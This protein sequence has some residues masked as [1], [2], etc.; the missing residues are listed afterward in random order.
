[1]IS[2]LG[3]AECVFLCAWRNS[4]QF[5]MINLVR[6]Y[7]KITSSDKIARPYSALKT[8]PY[9]FQNDP[10]K[11]ELWNKLQREIRLVHL[12][13]FSPNFFKM[14]SW[15]C[16]W[17]LFVLAPVTKTHLK[18]ILIHISVVLWPQMLG[19]FITRKNIDRECILVCPLLGHQCN[20][21]HQRIKNL[22]IAADKLRINCSCVKGIEN[23]MI[24]AEKQKSANRFLLRGGISE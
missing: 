5:W 14:I 24:W 19:I 18:C 10:L 9:P 2:S 15:E 22:A 6:H 13:T 11:K 4:E 8:S 21:E 7:F 16:L 1:M 23:P 12:G 17:F 20:K 3:C